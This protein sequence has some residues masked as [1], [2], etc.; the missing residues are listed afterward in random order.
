MK[1]KALTMCCALMLLA[2][3]FGAQTLNTHNRSS[4]L[5]TPFPEISASARTSTP[6][7]LQSGR[8][9]F[10]IITTQSAEARIVK[11]CPMPVHRP[12]TTRLEPMRVAKPSPN[13]SYSMPRAELKCPDPL[14]QAK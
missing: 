11:D 10:L 12:D 5:F 7:F 8:R 3:K 1:M 2:A 14:D 9:P 4:L 13:V 6:P